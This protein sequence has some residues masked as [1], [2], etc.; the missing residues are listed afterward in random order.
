MVSDEDIRV[1]IADDEP[2]AREGLADMLDRKE[3]VQIVGRAENGLE[4]IKFINTLQPDLVFLDIQM[5]G[6]TGIE[7]V[8]EVGI[9][10]MPAV[11]FVTAYDQYA[12]K[13]FDLSAVD[14]LLKPFDEERF[15]NA[16]ERAR[17]ALT[18]RELTDLRSRL[19]LLLEEHVSNKEDSSPP[20]QFLERV[21]VEMRG[22]IK[23]VPV[24]QI[25]YITASGSYVELHTGSDKY[26]I[27]ERMQ[28]LED[29]LDPAHYFRIHRGTIVKL[30]CIETIMYSPGGNYQ[31]RLH[32]GVRLKLGRSR[33]EELEQ[34][35]GLDALG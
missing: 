13:A 17:K 27:R 8:N 29:R 11:I 31:V 10:K 1:I 6:K 15:D 28:T 2:L 25:D 16:F 30:E 26:L 4:A 21:A 34:R 22:Q 9:D 32:N 20:K 35:L 14:Y 33:R 12:I 7:V 18:V 5:P 19:A 24:D 23:V 3:G